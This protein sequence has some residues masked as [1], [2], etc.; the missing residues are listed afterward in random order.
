MGMQHY[1][2][3]FTLCVEDLLRVSL[4]SAVF[5]GLTHTDL[6]MCSC[7]LT[8]LLLNY[9]HINLSYHCSLQA[10]PTKRFVQINLTHET[11]VAR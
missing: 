9:E 4:S 5:T 8:E 10:V 11:P 3:F 2:Y 1:K 6:H 7:D